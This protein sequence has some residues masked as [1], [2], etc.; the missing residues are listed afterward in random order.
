MESQDIKQQVV[1]ATKWSTITEI[2]AKLVAPISTMVLARILTPEA[3]GVLVTATM[4]ISFSEIFTDAGFQKYIIQQSFNSKKSLY[5]S[6]NV[7]F[8]SN[9]FLSLLIW[10]IIVI[11]C[12][13]IAELVGNK[14]RGDVIA[15]SCICIPLSAF[16][17]IQ[18]AVYKKSLNFRFLFWVRLVGVLIPL[19]VTIPLAFLTHSYWSLIIGMIGLQLSNAVLLTVKSEWKPKLWYDWRLFK[20]MFSFSAWSM[21]ES[22]SVWL[23]SYC[24]IFIVG[25]MLNDYYLGIYRTSMNTVGQIMGVIAAATTPVLFS[26]LSKVQNDNEQFGKILFKFQQTV[27]L[28]LM[29]MSVGLF[30]FRDFITDVLLGSQ[31]HQAAWFIGIWGLTSGITIVLSFFCSEVLRAKGKPRLS[32]ISQLIDLVVLIPIVWYGVHQSFDFLCSIRA[33]SRIFL[34]IPILLITYY[35]VKISPW[36]MLANINIPVWSSILMGVAGMWFLTFGQSVIWN[37]CSLVLCT[38]IY[39]S[40]VFAIP[41]TRHDLLNLKNMLRK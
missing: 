27:S 39:L 1:S 14:G 5:Q 10:L 2:A 33:L 32:T 26:S 9:L 21:L 8:V 24:D 22:L 41:K 37:I 19:V 29:P 15:V 16:S 38:L 13:D 6:T 11:F 36:K 3:F 30:I 28:I 7:A 25:T 18:M 20:G 35:S 12:Q 4:V 23:S 34:I 17:S 31:W 40:I